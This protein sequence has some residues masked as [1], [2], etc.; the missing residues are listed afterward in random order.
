MNFF[1]IETGNLKVD[2]GAM[3]GVV[4]KIL[5][6]KVYPADEN[7]LCTCAIRSLLIDTGT[8]KILVDTGIG[9]KQDKKFFGRFSPSANDTLKKSLDKIGYSF[10][11]IT[12]V[13]LTH[14]HFDHCGGCVKYNENGLLEIAFKNALYW[15]S[16][17]QW[18]WAKKPNKKEKASY[19]DENILPIEES[20]R[21]KLI[22]KNTEIYPGI[23]LKI[24]Y[25]HTEGLLSLLIKT[26]KNT[27]SFPGDLM[28]AAAYISLPYIAG[29]DIRPLETLKEKEALLRDAVE[30]NHILFFQHDLYNEC[31]TVQNVEKGIRMKESFRL[32]DIEF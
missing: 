5:W 27:L 31:C 32:T 7:N 6:Q 30:N 21:L 23:F 19:L 17:Q 26:P 20:G 25:G 9:D 18:D 10:D 12:D 14:L 11:D 3:F 16:R 8:K 22:E 29:Y 4:P 13:V 1:S 24:L 28:P 2:G 15:C